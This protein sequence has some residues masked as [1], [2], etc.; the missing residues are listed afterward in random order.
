MDFLFLPKKLFVITGLVVLTMVLFAC[1]STPEEAT[2]TGDY[3]I[4]DYSDSV[5]S[6][7]PFYPFIDYLKNEIAYIDSTPFAIEK[8][9]RIN[10]KLI[11]STL[12]D[13]IALRPM[14]DLFTSINP[15][16]KNLKPS[17]TESSFVDY[18]LNRLTFSI[19]AQQDDLPLQQADIHLHPENKRVKNVVLKKQFT[20]ADSS[21][22][23]YLVWENKM[24]FQ[25]S[26]SITKKTGE[27][28]SRVTRVVWDRPMNTIVP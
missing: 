17:Y 23:Q 3:I 19:T 27:G 16:A 22:L 11:D 9:V 1:N 2:D 4:K 21:V 14:F 13:R 18:T 25:I 6:N 7:E 5:N 8:T 24:H 12:I 20:H 15:E 10:G 28:Y 26:E